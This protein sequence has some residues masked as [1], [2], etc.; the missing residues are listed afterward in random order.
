MLL[1]LIVEIPI[2]MEIRLVL[3]EGNVCKET[4]NHELQN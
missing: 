2:K 4:K 3:T 1:K